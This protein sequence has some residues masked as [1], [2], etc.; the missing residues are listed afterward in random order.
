MCRTN[1]DY[2]VHSSVVSDSQE[3]H[4]MQKFARFD[5]GARILYGREN[6]KHEFTK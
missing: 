2:A 6:V 3:E 1:L 5:K 4:S